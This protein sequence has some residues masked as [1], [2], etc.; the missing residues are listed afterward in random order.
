[1][2]VNSKRKNYKVKSLLGIDALSSHLDIRDGR[3]VKATNLLFSDGILKKRK[4]WVE[5]YRFTDEYDR[6]LKINGICKHGDDY[7][8]HAGEYLF[9]N[10]E[11]IL[12]AV[13][14]NQRSYFYEACGNLY[15]VCGGKM[16]VYNG[17]IT[18]IY[19]SESAYVPYTCCDASSLNSEDTSVKEES[20]SLLTAKRKNTLIGIKERNAMYMLD[21]DVDPSK[22]IY[23][24]VKM[25]VSYGSEKENECPYYALSNT[26]TELK[27]TDLKSVLGIDFSVVE[28]LLSDKGVSVN[29]SAVSETELIFK[30]PFALSQAELYAKGE[31]GVPR[32]KFFCDVTQI[33]DTVSVNSSNYLDL[34]AELEDKIVDRIVFYG[35]DGSGVLDKIRILGR[36]SY[37]GYV[38]IKYEADSFNFNTSIKPKSITDDMG[39]SLTIYEGRTLG[40]YLGCNI[41]LEK[42]LN[43]STLIR[44]DYICVSDKMSKANIEIQYTDKSS[45][46]TTF[47]MGKICKT[48]TGEDILVLSDGKS[49]C[50]CVFKNGMAYAPKHLKIDLNRVSGICANDGGAFT[51]FSEDDATAFKVTKNDGSTQYFLEGYYSCGGA[52]SHDS[53]VNVNSDIISLSYEGVF[54]L[55]NEKSRVRRGESIFPLL[56]KDLSTCICCEH[57]GCYYLFFDGNVLVADSRLKTYE[58]NRLDS[59]YQYEWIYL[60]NIPASYVANIDGDLLIGREDGRV[61]SFYDGYSD[62][63]YEQIGEGSYLFDQNSDGVSIIYLNKDI[64]IGTYDTV[65]LSGCYTLLSGIYDSTLNGDTITLYL[66]HDQFYD[67]GGDMKIFPCQTI[68]LMDNEGEIKEAT[69]IDTDPYMHT[70][71]VNGAV[72]NYSM[73]LHKNQSTEYTLNAE[74]DHYVILNSQGENVKLFMTENATLTAKKSTPVCVEYE[75]APLLRDGE[76]ARLYGIEVELTKETEGIVTVEHETDKH[77]SVSCEN[78]GQAFDFDRLDFNLLSFNTSLKKKISL[79]A[80]E[81]NFDYVTGKIKHSESTAFGLVGYSV[82]YA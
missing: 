76:A 41:S 81:R 61:V 60:D 14:E 5:K 50:I 30:T 45:E 36:K 32:V 26:L 6:P 1:M 68:Y 33:Y 67:I 9:K 28:D 38:K 69:V 57:N 21:G 54:G 8:F 25:M 58:S 47:S 63:Y 34:S 82:S 80:F 27:S 77:R 11:R 40:A 65:L 71:T 73:I 72:G 39:N 44:F 37:N 74:G 79:R 43:N 49:V 62:I 15:I 56:P 22:P 55:L 51:G 59:S 7:I 18:E 13:L 2:G 4:G 16:Y 10:S 19:D 46:K 23:V 31:S 24:D 70:V 42:S 53:A 20:E 12:G 78:N 75:S 17:E 35:N 52:I 64:N 66:N 3:C 48:D 29:L